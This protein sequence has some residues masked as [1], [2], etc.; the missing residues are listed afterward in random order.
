MTNLDHLILPVNDRDESVDFYVRILGFAYE[1]EQP[2]FSVVRVT[3]DL[4]LQ[5]APWG[6][7]GGMHLAFAMTRTE[8]DAT[9]GRLRESA[10]EYGDS[11]HAVGNMQGPGEEPGSRGPGP[12]IYFFDPSKHLIEIRY[13]AD[14]AK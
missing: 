1:R 11:F 10:I 7:D 5:I 14:S 6:S 13:Y 8:F 12:T 9:F 4:T 2:P 3:P